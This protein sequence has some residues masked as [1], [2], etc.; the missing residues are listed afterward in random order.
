VWY[1][2][3]SLASKLGFDLSSIPDIDLKVC[4]FFTPDKQWDSPKLN[5]VLPP[6]LVQSVQ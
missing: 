1:S 2:D 6:K 3:E 4:E 5:Q